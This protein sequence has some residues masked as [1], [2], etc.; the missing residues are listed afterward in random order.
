[1]SIEME[2]PQTPIQ[3]V[4]AAWNYVGQLRIALGVGDQTHIQ[5][6]LFEIDRLL[7]VAMEELENAE[8]QK[9]K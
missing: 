8:G 3:L 2:N 9:S 5:K 6:C 1:M 7:S 4:D